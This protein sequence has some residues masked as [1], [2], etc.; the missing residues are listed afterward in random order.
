M[1]SNQIALDTQKNITALGKYELWVKK[2]SRWS[3]YGAV[4]M[5]LL[6]PLITFLDIVGSK[7]FNFPFPGSVELTGL[8]QTMLLPLA[9]ALTLICGQHIKVDVFT[10]RLSTKTKLVLDSI[11]SLLLC[12]FSV[13]LIWQIILF[14]MSNIESG[15]YSNTLNLPLYPFIFIMALAIVPLCLAFFDGFLNLFK[16]RQK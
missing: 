4:A 12:M 10:D 11:I 9:A 1:R 5:L 13:V 2:I 14:G 7:F 16:D 8:L 15:E 6:I 3:G